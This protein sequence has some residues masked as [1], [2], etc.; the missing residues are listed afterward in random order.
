MYKA[1]ES[2]INAS[3]KPSFLEILDDSSKHAGHAAMKGLAPN[4]THFRVTI[5]SDS[6]DGLPLIKRHRM[7]NS[8]LDNELKTGLH[9]L[10]LFTKTEKEFA[11]NK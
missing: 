1:I 3:L 2:K 6:F 5:V 10:Q 9:A 11:S 8:L 4:E 7:V